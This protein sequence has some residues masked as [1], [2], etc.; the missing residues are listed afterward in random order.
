MSNT[1]LTAREAVE[2][3][4]SD[5]HSYVAERCRHIP[6]VEEE[7]FNDCFGWSFYEALISDLVDYSAAVKFSE[8]AEYSVGA[9]VEHAGCVYEVLV[10]T[11]I[12]GQPIANPTYFRKAPKFTTEANQTL[13]DKYLGG[14]IAFRVMQGG[15]MYRSVKDTAKGVVKAFDPDGSRPA[16]QGEVRAVKEELGDDIQRMIKAMTA[17]IARNAGSYP[18]YKAGVGDCEDGTGCYSYNPR[19][20]LGFNVEK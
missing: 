11:G 1:L 2:L 3:S 5:A 10:D 15:I 17:Y 4:P 8:T 6:F 12:T 13:W 7:L 9:F 20:T 16:T 18:L 19:K 14:I